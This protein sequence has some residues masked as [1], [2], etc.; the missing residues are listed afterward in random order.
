MLAHI[1]MDTIILEK[2][3]TAGYLENRNWF[4]TE[5]GTPQGGIASPTLANMVLDGLERL[6]DETFRKKKIDGRI[7]FPK[8]NLVRYADDCAPRAR[9]EL[10]SSTRA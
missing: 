3:L 1:P 6:L 8:I 4:P 9:D 10:M 5:A 7:Q 2:W